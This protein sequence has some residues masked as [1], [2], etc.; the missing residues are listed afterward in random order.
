MDPHAH[1]GGHVLML[2]LLM[3]LLLLLLYGNLLGFVPVNVDGE[4]L[5]EVGVLDPAVGTRDHLGVVG[6]EVEALLGVD[7]QV[8]AVVALERR[9]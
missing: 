4:R 7:H 2:V 1:H 5:A 8:A 9:S 3:L 6:E